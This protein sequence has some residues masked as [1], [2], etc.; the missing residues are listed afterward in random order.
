MANLSELVRRHRLELGQVARAL[1][2]HRE[3][4]LTVPVGLIA[5]GR[6]R[7]T[8]LGLLTTLI[9]T[10][11]A[12]ST[13]IF[14]R[15]LVLKAERGHDEAWDTLANGEEGEEWCAVWDEVVKDHESGAVLTADQLTNLVV[16]ARAGFFDSPKE[17]LVIHREENGGVTSAL[18]DTGWFS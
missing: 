6:C 17:L 15:F 5:H 8:T 16:K 7:L 18:L 1:S 9:P 12:A 2:L 13:E 3:F 14:Q 4:D 11:T 10:S